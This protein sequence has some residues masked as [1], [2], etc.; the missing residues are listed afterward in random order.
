MVNNNV[1]YITKAIYSNK[2]LINQQENKKNM[3][4]IMKKIHRQII[5]LLIFRLISN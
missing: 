3:N 5:N 1:K 4:M 2:I